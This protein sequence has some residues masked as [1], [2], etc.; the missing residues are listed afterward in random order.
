MLD[1]YSL[2]DIRIKL[3]SAQ[4]EIAFY[5]VISESKTTLVYLYPTLNIAVF[6]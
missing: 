6:F 3:Y 5:F 4:K 2:M 1:D